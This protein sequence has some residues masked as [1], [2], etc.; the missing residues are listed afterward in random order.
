MDSRELASFVDQVVADAEDLFGPTATATQL[1]RHARRAVLNL[2]IVRPDVVGRD[3]DEMLR[4]VQT[5]IALRLPRR[6]DIAA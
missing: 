6:A 2:S 3:A 4:H 5:A 1:R